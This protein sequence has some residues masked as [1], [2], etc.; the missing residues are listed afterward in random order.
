ME[1]GALTE[2]RIYCVCGQKMKVSESMFGLP[3]KCVACR[4]KIR[5]PFRHEVPPDTIEIH[6]KDHPELIRKARP[7]FAP[8]RERI[9]GQAPAEEQAEVPL[10]EPPGAAAPPVLDILEPLRVLFSLEHKITRR[11]AALAAGETQGVEADRNALDNDLERVR[12][13]RANLEETLRK[14]MMETSIELASTLERI[15]QAG[16]SARIGEMEFSAFRDTVD[17]LRHRREYLERLQQNLRAWLAVNDPHIAGGYAN[18]SL[19]AIPSESVE[20]VLPPEPFDSRSLFDIHI[21]GLREALLRRERAELRLSEVDRLKD[22]A[23]MS[24]QVLADCRAD[25][26]AEKLRAE[27]EVTFRRR[28]LE[29]VSNDCATEVQTI[30]ACLDHVQK[31]FESGAMD[32]AR[33]NAAEQEMIRVQRDCARVHGLVARALMA[34]TARDVPQPS[35]SLIKRM[36]RPGALAR[37]VVRERPNLGVDSWVAWGSAFALGICAFLPLA[38]DMSPLQVLRS[39]TYQGPAIHWV[40]IIPILAGALATLVGA[41]P[42]RLPRGLGLILVWLAFTAICAVLIHEAQY[43]M[44]P[45][46]ARFRQGG[47]WFLRSGMV[48]LILADLGLLAAAC[49]AL[50]PLRTGRIALPAAVGACLVLL[51]I[52]S[53]NL[54]G[55]LTPRPEVNVTWNPIETGTGD[56]GRVLYDASITVSNAGY[57]ALLLSSVHTTVCQTTTNCDPRNSYTYLLEREKSPGFWQDTAVSQSKEIREVLSRRELVLHQELPPDSYRVRLIANADGTIYEKAFVLPEPASVREEK[58]VERAPAASPKTSETEATAVAP[59][60]TTQPEQTQSSTA[61]ESPQRPAF[62]P[63]ADVEL[64]GVVRNEKRAPRFSVALYPQNA[65]PRYLDLLIGDTLY[66]PWKITEF[67]PARQTVTVSD[68]NRILILNR[69]QRMPLE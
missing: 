26:Q 37:L 29:Q 61:T 53:S 46:A 1:V 51:L 57:R 11:L 5:I 16:L 39:A 18:V 67:N 22:E 64:R 19:D 56:G 58:P 43:G 62:L 44:D 17:R 48:L 24:P 59:S 60:E 45:L 10:G 63:P 66:D 69:G 15:A 36:V 6:L 28:R 9:P 4:Q 38:N 30:Q 40:L 54:A 33:F 14:R 49:L 34:S 41:L 47:P 3:G 50:A 55:I 25:S 7:Q 65:P 52:V 20:V 35:G 32:K 12:N 27:A 8:L 42:D 2:L 31:R 21:D 23:T 13:A 68:G